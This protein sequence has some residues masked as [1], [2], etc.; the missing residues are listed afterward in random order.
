MGVFAGKTAVVTGASS[1]I[2]RA[3]ALRLGAAGAHVFVAGRREGALAG[4]VAAVAGAGGVATAVVADLREAGAVES[5]VERAVADTGRLD[6]MV[7]NAG[8]SF[9]G[10]LVDG[11]PEQWREMLEVNVLAP[12]AGARAA[13][14]AMRAC[15]AEGH[16]VTISSSATRVQPPPSLYGFYSATKAAVE[17]ITTSLRQELENDTIRV[18][19]VIPGTTATNL[20]RHRPELVGGL[21]AALG[22]QAEP[23]AD[24]LFSPETLDRVA[25]AGRIL[26]SAD[27]VARAVMFAITQPIELSMSEIAVG[28]ARRPVVSA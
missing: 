13:V 6:V 22:E 9:R 8:V 1:G 2:G 7:N 19:T 14:R 27:D 28:P 20:G 10:P 25:A 15:G 26:A 17:A 21:A 16:I 5:L 3:V 18:V 24:G 23:S 12:A 4:K 11:D